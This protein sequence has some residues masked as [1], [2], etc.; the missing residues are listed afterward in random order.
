MEIFK[1]PTIFKTNSSSYEELFSRFIV[2]HPLHACLYTLYIIMPPVLNNQ[3]RQFLIW[4]I[5]L[6]KVFQS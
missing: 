2:S 6:L 1:F 5:F 3:L 4:F